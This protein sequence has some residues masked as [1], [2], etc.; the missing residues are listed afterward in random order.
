MWSGR[1]GLSCAPVPSHPS[2]SEPN[3]GIKSLDNP[4]QVMKE[5]IHWAA[6]VI[7]DVIIVC[8]FFI[9]TQVVLV[10]R[11]DIRVGESTSCADWVTLYLSCVTA[12]GPLDQSSMGG[13]S[14]GL[15]GPR[16]QVPDV[17]VAR[18]RWQQG[19]HLWE[20]H[21]G[22]TPPTS[23]PPMTRWP[24]PHRC[25]P[26]LQIHWLAVTLVPLIQ[27][28]SSAPPNLTRQTKAMKILPTCTGIR[29]RGNKLLWEHFYNNN[30][31]KFF[32]FGQITIKCVLQTSR[33]LS[34]GLR[35]CW[36]SER[37]CK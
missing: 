29:E 33:S 34:E 28:I 18:D 4:A 12:L 17:S 30:K 20:C 24:T 31:K 13:P 23:S 32:L 9:Q 22:S 11:T 6:V 19:H 35:F 21:V 36:V 8:S 5:S 2:C 10:N 7:N 15:H 3:L 26:D 1:V 27:Q 37:K 16:H 14:P 25:T